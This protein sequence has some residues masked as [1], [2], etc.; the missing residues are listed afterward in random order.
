MGGIL[1]TLRGRKCDEDGGKERWKRDSKDEW[2]WDGEE[3]MEEGS[4]GGT[5]RS[6]GDVSG[7]YDG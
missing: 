4:E 1:S 6:V 3:N 2:R 7:K 5:G